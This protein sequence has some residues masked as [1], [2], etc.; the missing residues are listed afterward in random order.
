MRG[1]G[2]GWARWL[3][4]E[5]ERRLGPCPIQ[6]WV[7]VVGRDRADLPKCIRQLLKGMMNTFVKYIIL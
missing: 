4:G 5:A 3:P 6:V 7:V 2:L 1:Y